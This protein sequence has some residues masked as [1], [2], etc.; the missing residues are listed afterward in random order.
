[1]IDTYRFSTHHDVF[2]RTH[3]REETGHVA[4]N[5]CLA[6]GLD[7]SYFFLA[8]Q[9]SH[10]RDYDVHAG[11]GFDEC[12]GYAKVNRFHNRAAGGEGAEKRLVDRGG[13]DEREYFL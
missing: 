9:Q 8:L 10:A 3:R 6:G 5:L 4:M 11:N 7:K 2:R 13:A 1:V 12:V